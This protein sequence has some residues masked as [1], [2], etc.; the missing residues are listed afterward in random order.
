[1]SKTSRYLSSANSATLVN[2]TIGFV[3]TAHLYMCVGDQTGIIYARERGEE[4]RAPAPTTG[5]VCLP[6]SPWQLMRCRERM[7]QTD[8]G[9]ELRGIRKLLFELWKILA[10][11]QCRLW[12]WF[13][14]TVSLSH[15]IN[16][17]KG[18]S[19]NTIRA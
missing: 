6:P 9:E 16:Q 2:Y 15:C 19:V 17:P 3:L 18:I 13:A 10:Q 12:R 5:S 4:D 11:S 8:A 7:M 1:M 14:E